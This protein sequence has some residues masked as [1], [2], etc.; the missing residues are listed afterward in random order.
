VRTAG[1]DLT[2]V[3]GELQ[4]LHGEL[5][6]RRL[7]PQAGEALRRLGDTGSRS[8]IVAGSAEAL[9]ANAHFDVVLVSRLDGEA[10]RPQALW[11]R[12]GAAAARER[13]AELQRRPILVRYPLVEA[14]V[15][16]RHEAALVSVAADGGRP[17]LALADVL[18]SAVYAVA[19]VAIEGK[20]VGFV[21]AARGSGVDDLDVA[22]VARYAD[23]L[24]RAFERAVLREQLDRERAQLQAAARWIA[25]QMHRLGELATPTADGRPDLAALLTAR[26]LEVL[27]LLARG[28]SNRGIAATLLIGEGTV[29]YHVKNI[30]RKLQARGRA[31][32][33][34]RYMRA[35]GR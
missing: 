14:E 15:A 33:V 16:R 5:V 8:A 28:Q 7:A 24:A 26:E 34:S 4:E 18:E 30:L 21:H 11:P 17:L 9:G 1:E 25:G 6:E 32:A 29:K 31:D 27:R 23:G 13:L 10:L 2:R 12:D 20:A 22:V 3:L 19:D 35:D